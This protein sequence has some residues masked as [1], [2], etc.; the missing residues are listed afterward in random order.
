MQHLSKPTEPS[1]LPQSPSV[2]FHA[3]DS[4]L[5]SIR[6]EKFDFTRKIAN[7]A[8]SQGVLTYTVEAATAL[9]TTLLD[10]NHAH[11]FIGHRP[12]TSR[13]ILHAMP[14]YIWGFWYLDPMGVN[15]HASL[16]TKSF[17]P[18]DIDATTATYF[19]NGVSGHMLRHNVSKF[20]QPTSKTELPSAHA[21]LFLQEIDS[22]A[23]PVHHI[24]TQKMIATVAK[25]TE[26]RV[27]VKLHPAQ[28]EVF[29]NRYTSICKRFPNVHISDQSIHAL[30]KASDIVVTQN[31]A[32]G[33][34]A[35]L[36]KKPVITCARTDYHHATLVAHTPQELRKALRTA[37]ATLAGFDYAKYLYWFLSEHMLEP[38]QD[39]FE[40]RT[41]QR[42]S[43]LLG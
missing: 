26:R 1:A 28:S 12:E 25:S 34:E 14:S 36:Q 41:W 10:Q 38:Q 21:V 29:C 6:D 20:A 13:P 40:A 42:I 23:T 9:S 27:Y 32:A 37:Q 24:D 4:W 16:A 35:L 33:F 11:I 18:E 15:W 22:Y 43:P 5:S 3:K 7:H 30:T 2:I 8:Q 19:F 17:S 39:T 31:S